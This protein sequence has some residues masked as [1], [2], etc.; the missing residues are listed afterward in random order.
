MT[1]RFVPSHVEAPHFVNHVFQINNLHE[2]SVVLRD[3]HERSL[4]SHQA[5]AQGV[6][7]PVPLFQN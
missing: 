3:Q 1:S 4:D 5:S 2:T 7:E 6:R